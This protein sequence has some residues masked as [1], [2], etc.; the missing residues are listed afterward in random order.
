MWE[1]G[2][3]EVF[4]F[5]W[6]SGISICL[7]AVLLSDGGEQGVDGGGAA[8]GGMVAMTVVLEADEGEATVHAEA[9]QADE[10]GEVGAEQGDGVDDALDVFFRLEKQD[11]GGGVAELAPEEDFVTVEFG[12]GADFDEHGGALNAGASQRHP[13][14]PCPIPSRQAG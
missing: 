9:L 11:D 13:Q 5:H 1:G 3:A 8:G 4:E 10:A 12:G 6:P 2:G 14:V 7:V